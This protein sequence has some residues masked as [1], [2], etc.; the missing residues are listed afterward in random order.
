[1]YQR[2]MIVVDEGPV[3]RS[4]L[5]QGLALAAVHH[6]QVLFFHVLPSYVMPVADAPSLVLMSP[7]QHRQAVETVANRLLDQAAGAARAA[8]VESTSAIGSD[9]DAAACIAKFAHERGCDLLVAGSHGRN[10]LQRLIF[11]SLV[12]R[13]IPLVAM[14][15]LVCK[16][17]E[18]SESATQAV[19]GD[20][21][22]TPQRP[23]EAH[24]GMDLPP[25]A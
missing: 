15:L 5:D 1:M 7:E 24:P 6:A 3:A 19:S 11:G 2:I 25:P 23:P 22:I 4:A 12:V 9:A 10:A 17:P 13:L 16:P 21:R 8:G 14:P 20:E 18:A